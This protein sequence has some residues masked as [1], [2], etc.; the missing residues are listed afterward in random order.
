M[1]GSLIYCST[2]STQLNTTGRQR[3][4]LLHSK[5]AAHKNHH[6]IRIELAFLRLCCKFILF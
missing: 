1:F 4:S 6:G 3:E 5:L 2:V